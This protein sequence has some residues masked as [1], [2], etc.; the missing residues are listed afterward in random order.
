MNI[1]SKL[2][3]V[4]ESNKTWKSSVFRNK[5]CYLKYFMNKKDKVLNII[6]ISKEIFETFSW[7]I[8]FKFEIVYYMIKNLNSLMFGIMN[9]D[10]NIFAIE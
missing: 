10:L 9:W 6:A 2:K 3:L 7:T 1:I 4:C 5:K 8:S